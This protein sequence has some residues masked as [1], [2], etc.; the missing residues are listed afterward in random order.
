MPRRFLLS[1]ALFLV[2][3]GNA[4][5]PTRVVKQLISHGLWRPGTDTMGAS[6]TSAA[7]CTHVDIFDMDNDVRDDVSERCTGLVFDGGHGILADEVVHLLSH[8]VDLTYSR[9]MP[10]LNISCSTLLTPS[11]P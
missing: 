9:H 7:N 5:S 2:N 8:A 3:F 6:S 11:T 10:W 1:F 4:S